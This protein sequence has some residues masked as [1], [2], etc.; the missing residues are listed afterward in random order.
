MSTPATIKNA[1]TLPKVYF[2]LHMVEGVAE[3]K[4]PK[5]N[6]GEPWRILVNEDEIK[7]MDASFQGRPVYV[8]HVD[9]VD[10]SNIQN[11]ADGYVVRSFYNP[12][13]GKHWCEF[14]VVSDAGHEA[15]ARK[16]K[17]SNAYHFRQTAGGGKWHGVDYQK[18]VMDGEYDHLAIVPNPRYAESIILT[19][20][21]FKAYNAEKEIELKRLANSHEEKGED[22]MNLNFFKKTKVENSEELSQMSVTLPKSKREVSVSKLINEADDMAMTGAYANGDHKVKVGEEEMSVNQLVEKHWK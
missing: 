11:E 22:S 17:L 2:G 18:R 3:Y 10:L 16:W 4:D 5:V 15:I 21:E 14:L 1:H 19:P 9:A 7:N 13:D 12:A 6:N 8:L 20:E